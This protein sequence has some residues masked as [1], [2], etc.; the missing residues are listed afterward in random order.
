MNAV[1]H[2]HQNGITHRDIKLENIMLDEEKENVKLIDFGFATQLQGQYNDEILY[3]TLGTM[4]YMAPE[5]HSKQGYNGK[6]ID[7]FAMAVVLF[8]MIVG[9][10]PFHHTM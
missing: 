2:C 4:Q 8:Q 1:D 9:R 3:E 5:L 6:S 7:I 10:P